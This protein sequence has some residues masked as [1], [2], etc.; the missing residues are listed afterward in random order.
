MHERLKQIRKAKKLSQKDFAKSI[1]LSQN[2]ISSIEQ[3]IR[4]L[5]DRTINDICRTYNINKEWFLTGKGD[6]FNDPLKECNINDK[7]IEEFARMFAELDP[8]A[9]K[10]ISALMKKT[11]QK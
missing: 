10:L 7:E 3:G 6:M 8:E 2:H 11:L 5:T 4:K 1:N 9:R